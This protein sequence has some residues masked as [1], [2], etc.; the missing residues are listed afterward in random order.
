MD[1]RETDF[2]GITDSA[3]CPVEG[4]SIFSIEPEEMYM[5]TFSKSFKVVFCVTPSAI[6]IILV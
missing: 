6:K 1:L 3:F 4:F 2:E 5:Y